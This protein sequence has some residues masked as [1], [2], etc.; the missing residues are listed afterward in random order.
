MPSSPPPH[1]I[2]ISFLVTFHFLQFVVIPSFH[3]FPTAFL[4]A[5]VSHLIIL[6]AC[7]GWES[8]GVAGSQHLCGGGTTA[9]P[10]GR[11]CQDVH[12]PWR[13]AR[14]R[15][16]ST[17]ALRGVYIGK[18]HALGGGGCQL[19]S[20]GEKM[21]KGEEK[22]LKCKRKRKKTGSKGIWY[23]NANRKELRQKGHY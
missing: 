20:F 7:A 18:Y 5:K 11:D 23:I 22:R 4:V 14:K 12:H 8:P 2:Y 10:G 16:A 19:M 21:W 17:C 13:T 1:F 6:L 15:K 9:L 3:I